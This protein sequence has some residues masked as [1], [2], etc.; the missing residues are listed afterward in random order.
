MLSLATKSFARKRRIWNARRATSFL[1]RTVL[2]TEGYEYP[3]KLAYREQSARFSGYSVAKQPPAQGFSPACPHREAC[4]NGTGVRSCEEIAACV[5]I[6]M[7]FSFDL[8]LSSESARSFHISFLTGFY[9]FAATSALANA[10]TECY[11]LLPILKRKVNK[12]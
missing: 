12:D 4:L 2:R 7:S 11:T 5:A 6:R 1:R 9:R 8:A 10:L 3:S